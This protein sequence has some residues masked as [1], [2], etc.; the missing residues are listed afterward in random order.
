MYTVEDSA[1]GAAL[2]GTSAPPAQNANTSCT[3]PASPLYSVSLDST[4]ERNSDESTARSLLFKGPDEYSSHVKARQAGA[5][6][7]G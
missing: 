7:D 4:V 3:Q 1:L 6:H 5:R 2:P